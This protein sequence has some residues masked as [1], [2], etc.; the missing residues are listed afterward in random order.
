M[1]C[2]YFQ[3]KKNNMYRVSWKSLITSVTGHG[4]WNNSR[5]FI[6]EWVEFGNK[7]H[8]GEIEHWI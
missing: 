7:E 1:N 2:P 3:T 5:E 8:L 4:Y 6:K